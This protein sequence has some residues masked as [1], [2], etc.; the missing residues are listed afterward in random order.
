M[1]KYGQKEVFL[2]DLKNMETFQAYSIENA[3]SFAHLFAERKEP[4]DALESPSGHG[5]C[6]VH[7][8][9]QSQLP[10]DRIILLIHRCC[11]LLKQ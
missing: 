11:Q 6:L 8:L 4:F 3:I 9:S 5:L 10:N 2:N 1:T 7:L